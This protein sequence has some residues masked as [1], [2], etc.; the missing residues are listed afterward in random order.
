MSTLK[1]MM[2][3]RIQKGS[4]VL[5]LLLCASVIITLFPSSVYADHV[6]PNPCAIERLNIEP[7]N[8]NIVVGKL[9]S[10]TGKVPVYD[11]WV[12]RNLISLATA[13]QKSAEFSELQDQDIQRTRDYLRLLCEK[14]YELDHT[15]QHAW[16][17]V[18]DQFVIETI[19]W[20]QTVYN[21]NPIFVTN[22]SVYYKLVDKN[23]FSTFV[24]EIAVSQIGPNN[25]RDILRYLFT[26]RFIDRFPYP[27]ADVLNVPELAPDELPH[28][29]QRFYTEEEWNRL[30]KA[31]GNVVGVINI[32][33]TELDRRIRETRTNEV[34]KLNWGR[35]F[36]SYEVCDLTL[37][38][39]LVN[40]EFST[41]L[42][43]FPQDRRNCRIVTPGSLIQDQT[44]LVLGSALRQMELA[45]EVDE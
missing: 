22:Q 24:Q 31:E 43:K 20:V 25:K 9:G 36:F 34:N 29:L 8:V 40:T 37:F 7:R 27:L 41:N 26:N 33:Q 6:T 23:V 19:N 17:K 45:D 14:E 30:T 38:T 18:I 16:A 42:Q 28:N 2:N 4:L 13:M 12:I 3:A 1:I 44:S 21:D 5:G 35:G 15:L 11:E 39:R 32:A 10:R